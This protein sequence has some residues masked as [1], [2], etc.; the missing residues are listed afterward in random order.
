MDIKSLKDIIESDIFANL[1]QFFSALGTVGA[2]IFSLVLTF[3]QNK[4]KVKISFANCNM[5][6]TSLRNDM[7][8]SGYSVTI[9]NCSNEKNIYLKQGLYM[10]KDKTKKEK[11]D[12]LLLIPVPE[13]GKEFVAPK[14]LGPGEEFMFFISEKQ[15][16]AI[17]EANSSK[18]IKFYFMDKANKKYK[19]KIKRE[20]F[21]KELK[22]IEENGNKILSL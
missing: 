6:P 12:L 14:V 20:E 1:C 2:V 8:I 19:F 22:F 21:I 5:I 18:K 3:I 4:V 16:K 17:L 15:I 7:C 11:K 10:F 13:L 9:Y